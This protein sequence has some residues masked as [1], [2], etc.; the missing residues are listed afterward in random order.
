MPN[1]VQMRFWW[2]GYSPEDALT[3][4]D[5]TVIEM[6]FEGTGDGGKTWRRPKPGATLQTIH[7]WLVDHDCTVI[8]TELVDE[9]YAPHWEGL[10][11]LTIGRRS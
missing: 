7:E 6:P 5:L 1:R 10:Y 8:H 11:V 2:P 9:R 3:S 4:L